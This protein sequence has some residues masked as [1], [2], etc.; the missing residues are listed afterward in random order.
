[1]KK[2]VQCAWC[3]KYFQKELSRI[4]QT[5][6]LGQ[7][8]TCCR[9]CASKLTNENRKHPPTTKRALYSRNEKEKYPEKINARYLVRQATK[10][11]RLIPH[12]ECELCG[13]TNNVQPHHPDYNQPFLL[14]YLCKQCHAQADM[15][16]D[17]WINLATNY[18]L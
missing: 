7:L 11:G 5:E 18:N 13:S 4:K 14:I 9:S 12:T 8:H 3:K 16:I 10:S 17:K 2:T 6:R 15:A 1:M